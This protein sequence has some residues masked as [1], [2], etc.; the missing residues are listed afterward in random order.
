MM[1]GF[2]TSAAPKLSKIGQYFGKAAKP[3]AAGFGATSGNDEE[4][5]EVDISPLTCLKG[6]CKEREFEFKAVSNA[7]FEGEGRPIG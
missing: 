4:A 2:W 3:E 7:G 6:C 1:V 5:N